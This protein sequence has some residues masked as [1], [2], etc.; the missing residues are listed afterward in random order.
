MESV[1]GCR[2]RVNRCAS[3][4]FF[5]KVASQRQQSIPIEP[6]PR[7]P[8]RIVQHFLQCS[9]MLKK[10]LSLLSHI[11]QHPRI[12]QIWKI[13][14]VFKDKQRGLGKVKKKKTYRLNSF[15]LDMKYA[16]VCSAPDRRRNRFDRR[17]EDVKEKKIGCH[18]TF[19]GRKMKGGALCATLT[20]CSS[21]GGPQSTKPF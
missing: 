8:S 9:H 13:L 20:G 3:V 11:P 1:Y 6:C 16:P 2:C 12:I 19:H 21:N 10:V 4:F 15:G 5:L 7:R 17:R 18:N 14:L